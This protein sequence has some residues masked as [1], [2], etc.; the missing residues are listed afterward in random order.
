MSF[1]TVIGVPILNPLAVASIIL[2]RS[3]FEV[4]GSRYANKYFEFGSGVTTNVLWDSQS[5]VSPAVTSTA[6]TLFVILEVV[7][8]SCQAC[9]LSV[10][11]L[12]PNTTVRPRSES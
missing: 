9:I 6:A 7:K 10:L 1:V 3:F 12:Y 2:R 4:A 8:V 11:W 5:V